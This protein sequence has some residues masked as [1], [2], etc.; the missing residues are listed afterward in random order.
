[1]G[2]KRNLLLSQEN[3]S[4]PHLIVQAGGNWVQWDCS[5]N[6]KQLPQ[7]KHISLFLVLE[8][9]SWV[10]LGVIKSSKEGHSL[11][12]TRPQQPPRGVGWSQRDVREGE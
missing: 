3:V 4:F 1:M 10:T 2:E 6:L 12:P 9:W 7:E 5:P 8:K 11:L